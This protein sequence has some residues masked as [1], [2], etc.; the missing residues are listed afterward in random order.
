MNIKTNLLED[1]VNFFDS[2][3]KQN[4]SF[5]INVILF[6]KITT[7]FSFFFQKQ[8]NN[9]FSLEQISK[10]GILDSTSSTL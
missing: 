8:M 9:T 5:K 10:T 7:L 6:A 1:Y 3:K 4:T 2:T